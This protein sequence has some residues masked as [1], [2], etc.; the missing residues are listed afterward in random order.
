MPQGKN[1]CQDMRG[2][3]EVKSEDSVVAVY[4]VD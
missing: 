4:S 1:P 3:R 2:G